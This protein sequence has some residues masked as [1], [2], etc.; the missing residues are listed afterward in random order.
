MKEKVRNLVEGD[1]VDLLPLVEQCEIDLDV[2]DRAAVETEHAVVDSVHLEPSTEPSAQE[3]GV[4]FN[5]LVNLAVDAD[6]YVEVQNRVA[7]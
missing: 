6:M 5:K 2:G 3:I 4:I 7:D 1:I